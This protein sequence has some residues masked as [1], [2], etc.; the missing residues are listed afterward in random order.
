[1]TPKPYR[2]ADQITGIL[3]LVGIVFA[4]WAFGA[5]QVWSVL[6]LNSIGYLLGILLVFKWFVRWRTN[7]QPTRWSDGGKR[8]MPV[9]LLAVLTI[10]ILSYVLISIL[11]ARARIEYTYVSASEAASGIDFEY[12]ESFDWLPGTYDQKSTLW[13]FWKYLALSMAFWATRDWILGMSRRERRMSSVE[14]S[15]SSIPSERL[16]LVL[17]T[18]LLSAAALS[19][20]GIIQ[21]LDGTHKLLWILEHRNTPSVTYGPFPYR[22][23]ASDYLNLVWPIGIGFWLALR[24]RYIWSK[25]SAARAGG[26][27]HV[28]ILLLVSIIVVGPFMTSSRGGLLVEG[29]LMAVCGLILWTSGKLKP[30]ARWG[31]VSV[32]LLLIA[33]GWYL[34][35]TRIAERFKTIGTDRMS[36]RADIYSNSKRM[37]SEFSVY[38]SGAETFPKLYSLY[39]TKSGQQWEAYVHNDYLETQISFGWV[40]SALILG[41][42]ALV[43]I[44]GRLSP[45]MPFDR[46]FHYLWIASIGGLLLHARF[47]PPFQIYSI[48]F[49]FVILCAVWSCLTPAKE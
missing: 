17:W 41:A 7:F 37:A 48:H 43:P 23:T 28:V 21:R 26:G 29:A 25:G 34:G 12:L 16:S 22:G 19:L 4:P 11:N 15:Q 13:A 35:G 46:T 14:R 5:T 6:T 33:A 10:A 45:G 18:L 36:G 38:G 32:S 2:I 49:T 47:D 44:C 3:L 9:R 24:S 27:P 8:L 39:R 1:M 31:L 40:G 20:V 42:L 30:S